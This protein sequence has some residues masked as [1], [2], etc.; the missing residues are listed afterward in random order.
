MSKEPVSLECLQIASPCGERWDEMTGDEQ[1]RFCG[2]CRLNVYNL[3][4]M[5]REEAEALIAHT[6]GR[7][8]VRLYKREDGTVMTQ[9]CPVGLR[10]ARIK[11][12]KIAGAT[13]AAVL[14][15]FGP[16]NSWAEE[17]KGTSPSG[18]EQP[19]MGEMVAPPTQSPPNPTPIMG[20]VQIQPA[21][22]KT[23]P[24]TQPHVIMGKMAAPPS[25]PSHPPKQ[26]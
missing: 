18:Q 26:P 25:T 10:A 23:P 21:P 15:L 12:F 24:Q 17:R 5:P 4:A 14:S 16:L 20:D 19:L 8:C 11:L 13:A 2:K 3:S 1:V 7:L 22:P 6:E 9:D